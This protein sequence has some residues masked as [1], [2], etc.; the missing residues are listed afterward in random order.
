MSDLVLRS[1]GGLCCYV[2]PNG[3]GKSGEMLSLCCPDSHAGCE[4]IKYTMFVKN[5]T[6]KDCF[7]F[8]GKYV[9]IIQSKSKDVRLMSSYVR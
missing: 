8:T 7:L 5:L 3:G 4:I 2:R 1:C 6:L 9:F